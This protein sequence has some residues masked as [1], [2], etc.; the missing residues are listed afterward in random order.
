MKVRYDSYCGLNCGACPVGRANEMDDTEAIKKMATE[1]ETPLE[2]LKCTGCKT[3]ALSGYCKNCEM[4]VCARGKSLEFCHECSEYPC[5]LITRFRNDKASHHSAV[6]KN[7]ENIKT[8]GLIAWLKGEE[9]RWACQD[10]GSKFTWY[11]ESCEKCGAELYN[12]VQEEKE[13]RN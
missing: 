1:W 2:N 8:R 4:R 9:T 12:A 7:L 13:L 10:C 3:E 5:E 6:F 11:T